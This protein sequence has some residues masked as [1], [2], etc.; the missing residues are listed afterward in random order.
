MC[1]SQFFPVAGGAERQAHILAKHL[2]QKGHQIFVLT[3]RK[4]GLRRKE[5]LEGVPV[6]RLI[7]TVN[8]GPLFGL[9]FLASIIL[10]LIK[11]RRH[12]GIIHL[13]QA[14]LSAF[15]AG[16]LSGFLKKKVVVKVACGGEYGDM[17]RLER[18]KLSWLLFAGIKKADR[19]VAISEEIRRELL[20]YGFG[21]EKIVRIPNGVDLARFHPG[22]SPIKDEF[23]G[24]S[25]VLFVGRLDEQKGVKFL[26]RAWR[27]VKEKDAANCV[28]LL[29]GQGPLEAE[30]KAL[31]SSLN[32]G[33]SVRFLGRVENVEDYLK[34]AEVFV[35]PSLAEGMPNV[36]LEAMATGV[37][38]VA[39]SIGGVTDL[40]KD[41]ESAKLV[42]PRDEEKLATAI[43]KLL[44]DKACLPAGKALGE[45]LGKGALERVRKNFSIDA[46]GRRYEDL[47]RRL[48]A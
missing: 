29:I 5:V 15:A 22:R 48:S 1:L 36:L 9:S 35:L 34:A 7:R 14:Y 43:L 13:H 6:E 39:S 28:L 32:L 23:A 8:V 11:R 4:T 45:R 37:A 44:E 47:Y 26:L 10:L 18:M 33:E 40:V 41:G 27:K 16:L 17:R 24:R 3:Q 42:P 46:V 38:I 2:M 25:I 19:F 12:Y 20:S 30:L 31:A 21:E